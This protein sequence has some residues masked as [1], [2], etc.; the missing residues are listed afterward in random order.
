MELNRRNLYFSIAGLIAIGVMALFGTMFVFGW[1]MGGASADEVGASVNKLPEGIVVPT[2][3]CG[4]FM[5]PQ[6]V[7]GM[8]VEVTSNTIRFQDG[9]VLVLDQAPSMYIDRLGY[10][11]IA[12][13]K[14]QAYALAR[15]QFNPCP[16]EAA[17]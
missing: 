1:G 15:E 12:D 10:L 16:P 4:P 9:Y 7:G 11:Q 17:P 13:R 5:N 3:V 14:V 2:Q 6:I 8:P